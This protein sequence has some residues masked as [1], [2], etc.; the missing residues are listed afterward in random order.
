MLSSASPPPMDSSLDDFLIPALIAAGVA[1]LCLLSV[2]GIALYLCTRQK[3]GAREDVQ[4]TRT[5]QTADAVSSQAEPVDP[6]SKI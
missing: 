3:K 1:A 2:L 4:M 5:P 6:S